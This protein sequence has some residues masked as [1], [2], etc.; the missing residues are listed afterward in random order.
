MV[1]S[2]VSVSGQAPTDSGRVGES[3]FQE[4]ISVP[5]GQIYY[6]D[7]VAY[8]PEP[9][10]DSAPDFVQLGITSAPNGF[11]DINGEKISAAGRFAEDGSPPVAGVVVLGEY[12][13]SADTIAV[14][15]DTGTSSAPFYRLSIRRVL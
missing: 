6:V 5:D 15:F 12:A 10:E 13:Y 2:D 9:R 14:T 7:S 4:I 8:E 1:I 11:S 3:S